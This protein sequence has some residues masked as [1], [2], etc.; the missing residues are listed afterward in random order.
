MFWLLWGWSSARSVV[1]Q[2]LQTAGGLV[3]SKG[4]VSS[5][6]GGQRS[7]SFLDQPGKTEEK[8]LGLLP[9]LSIPS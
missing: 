9:R 2:S 3:H 1:K 5:T 8:P 7:R 4:A 6:P